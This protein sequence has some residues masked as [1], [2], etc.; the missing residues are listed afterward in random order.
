[1]AHFGERLRML[2]GTRSQKE[3]AKGL[4]MPQTTLS[5]L[6]NQQTVPRGEVLRRLADYFGTGVDYFFPSESAQPSAAARAYLRSIRHAI[7]D[8]KT[9]VTHSTLQLDGETKNKIH[10]RIRQKHAQTSHKR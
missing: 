3:V 2:R 1:M 7:P 4:R 5:T 8:S 6:E 10:E 9:V